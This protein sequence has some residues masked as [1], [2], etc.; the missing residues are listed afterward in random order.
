[1]SG[2]RG[3]GAARNRQEFV[4]EQVDGEGAERKNSRVEGEAERYNVPVRFIEAKNLAELQLIDG[5]TLSEYVTPFSLALKHPVNRGTD[6]GK[7]SR[8]D[9]NKQRPLPARFARR[10]LRVEGMVGPGR[11]VVG[12][13]RGEPRDGQ[14][15]SECKT[16]F[17]PLEP[18]CHGDGYGNNHGFGAQ[19]QHRAASD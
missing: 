6:H 2:L 14:V 16:E 11:R 8:A 9:G 10:T 1:M 5:S 4:R 15:N 17:F 7:N 3:G 18:L 12:G 19:A 13:D